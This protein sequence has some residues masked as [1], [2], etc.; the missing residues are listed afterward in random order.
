LGQ[1]WWHYDA[2]SGKTIGRYPVYSVHQDGMA[3]MA[4]FALSEISGNDFSHAIYRGL[5]WIAG[6]NELDLN[7]VDFSRNIIW[8]SF[9]RKKYKMY[10][11]EI[12]SLINLD[13][14]G[15]EYKDLTVLYECRPYHFG[16][17][18]YA[19]ADKMA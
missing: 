19:F 3:P 18:L 13:N 7:L 4:L 17:L 12:L 8:R 9:R 5:E 2:V 11:D 14:I 1:W 15:R 6:K 10:Y 16:W